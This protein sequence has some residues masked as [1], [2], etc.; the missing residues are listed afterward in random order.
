MNEI[1]Y[2]GPFKD[3]IRNHV[4]LKRAV[5]YKYD[6]DAS[7][8]KRFDRFTLEKYPDATALTKEIVLDWCSKKTY[9]AQANQCSR[10]SI[11]R[12][13]GKYLDSIGV[14]AYI[15]PK[16]YYP[17]EDP[18]MPYIYTADELTRFFAETDKCRYCCECPYRHLIMPVFFRMI[19]MCGLRVSEARLLKVA[20]VDLENGILTIHHS[21]KDNSRLVP[22]SVS[23]T[24][25]CR[26]YS[27]MVHPYS[28]AEEYYFPALNGKPMTIQNVYKN[29]RRFLW[30]AGISHGGRGKGPRIHD[31]RHTYAVHSLKKWSEQEKDLTVY[32]PV[33][34]TYMGHDSFEETAYYLRLTADVF[35]D[36]TLKLE[37]RYP[38]MIPELEGALNETD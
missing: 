32:L 15:L 24:E 37:T 19:Y 36:I 14:K 23:L 7:H 35:P 4:E 38:G 30:R 12:Q 18:Y 6:T 33:L 9:E 22:M 26:H 34:K 13:F 8:L 17:T 10:A 5:G 2:E 20:D 29:F 28:K 31:F 25:R 16:G 27:Q 1:I 3:H 21:K 11:I